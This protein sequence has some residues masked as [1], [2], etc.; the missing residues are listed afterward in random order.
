[1]D[2]SKMVDPK[3]ADFLRFAGD[4]FIEIQN[5]FQYFFSVCARSREKCVFICVKEKCVL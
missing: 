2:N 5:T 4:K 3:I 1:V